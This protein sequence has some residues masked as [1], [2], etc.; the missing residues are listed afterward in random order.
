MISSETFSSLF[1]P[2]PRRERREPLTPIRPWKVLL[3]DDEDDMHAV[4]H[5]ALKDMEVEGFPLQLFD[6]RS[7]DEAKGLL[8]KHPDISLILL[9]IVMETELAGLSLVTYVRQVICNRLV[10][11]VLVTGQPGYAP[12][13]EVRT[14]Y[15]IDGY[16]LKSELTVY[17]IYTSVNLALHA[18]KVLR[19]RRDKPLQPEINEELSLDQAAEL[20]R[21]WREELRDA[22]AAGERLDSA[23]LRRNDCCDLGKWLHS[24]GRRR[25][26]GKPQFVKLMARHND[27]HLIASMVANSINDDEFTDAQKM[28]GG[29]SQ[30]AQASIDVEIAILKLKLALSN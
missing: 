22:V 7:V 28:L 20:H 9:D 30:F 13:H 5:M 4:L 17:N 8:A 2:E 24:Q 10:Q 18:Y 21:K 29:N 15:E 14:N 25:Y 19:D 6:A 3:V 16:R 11:I 12:E 26:G 23:A 1:A 27:F